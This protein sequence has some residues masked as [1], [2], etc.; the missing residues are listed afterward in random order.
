LQSTQRYYSGFYL[1][2]I[3]EIL[4]GLSDDLPRFEV[5]AVRSLDSTH[6]TESIERILRRLG[7]GSSDSSAGAII[8]KDE[9]VRALELGTVFCGFD[10]IWL[11]EK[12]LPG[13][14]IPSDIS[15]TTD[16]GPASATQLNW[17]A[18]LMRE[19][20]AAAAL[21]DG[22]GLNCITFDEHFW[23]AVE[24]NTEKGSLSDW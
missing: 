13:C 24:A 18:H 2:T 10:E 22:C 20:R 4:L 23:R 7:I 11:L 12:P 14:A 3:P 17:V 21:G 8:A 9:L 19:L 1:A 16:C 15:L 6:E 5:A